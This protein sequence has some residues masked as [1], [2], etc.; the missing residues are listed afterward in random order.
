MGADYRGKSLLFVIPGPA[1]GWNPESVSAM[2]E[3]RF[4]IPSPLEL[5]TAPE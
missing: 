1:A 5:A 3:N 4:R 2:R